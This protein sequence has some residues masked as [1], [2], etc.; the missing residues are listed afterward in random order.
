MSNTPPGIVPA[1]IDVHHHAIPPGY[2][3]TLQGR[4]P[5]PNVDYPAWSPEGSLA[6]MDRNGIAAA[7]LSIT[8]PGIHFGDPAQTRHLAREIN[9]YFADLVRT[10][11]ARF[12]AFAILPLP[13]VAAAREELAYAIDEL[14]LDGIGL[15]TSYQ[16]L[17]LGEPAFEPLLA[18]LAERRLAVHV[19]PTIPPAADLDT[20]GLPPSLYEFTFETTRTVA[21]LLFNGVLDRLPDLRLIL[22]HAGGTLPFL[23][24]RLTYG[25][26]I[27]SYLSERAP[28]DIV[29][30]L[31][32]LHYDIAMSANRYALPSLAAL[33]DPGHTL[34]GS[35]Y[36]FMPEH[37]TTDTVAGLAAYPGWTPDE[38]AQ[39]G[40]ANALRLFPDI[41]ARLRDPAKKQLSSSPSR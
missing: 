18:E 15:L 12:G 25:P 32:R 36:P 1:L 35:D 13:D 21:S 26:V 22:S 10:Y 23:A 20:F 8:A 34:F 2:A 14:G 41:A 31:R 40:R 16:H 4:V 38:R 17:Y 11:P 33:A 24:Q 27:G 39:I 3:R 9:E 5:I 28:R 29:A 7:A 30:S 6:V 37:T 19:H